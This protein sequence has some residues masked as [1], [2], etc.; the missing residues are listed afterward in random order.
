MNTAF[1]RNSLPP[2]GF[3]PVNLRSPVDVAAYIRRVPPGATGKGMFLARLLEELDRRGIA[4]PTSERFLP[5]RDYPLQRCLELNVEA[6]RLMYPTVPLSDGLRRVAWNSFDTFA[7]S[8]IGQVL[9]SA[10]RHDVGSLLKLS[11][12]ALSHSTNVGSYEIELV[13][14]RTA[15][16]HVHDV[17]L[18]AE[19]FAIGMLEG[20]LRECEC[21]GE[22]LS[23]MDSTTSGAFYVRW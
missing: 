22:V 19:Y 1:A 13:R 16:F 11:S 10:V 21:D 14:E 20:L 4:R 12:S 17:F 15:I 3:G 7:N 9:F 6:A 23:R 5:F 8:L 2:G 18:F